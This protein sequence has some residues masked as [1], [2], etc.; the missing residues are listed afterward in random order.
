VVDI[1]VLPL[2]VPSSFLP[3]HR[4]TGIEFFVASVPFRTS[5]HELDAKTPTHGEPS[6]YW[7][8][9]QADCAEIC[10]NKVTAACIFVLKDIAGR[11]LIYPRRMNQMLNDFAQQV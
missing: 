6:R 11:K 3:E 2:I 10:R 5:A 7:P 1:S 4:T 9:R 8:A